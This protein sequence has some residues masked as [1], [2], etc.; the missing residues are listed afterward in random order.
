MCFM[1]CV[2]AC[3][4]LACAIWVGGL[5]WVSICCTLRLRRFWRL[6]AICVILVC[7]FS[8]RMGG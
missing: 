5:V 6:G 1:L 7:G 2:I 3:V 8:A 4:W